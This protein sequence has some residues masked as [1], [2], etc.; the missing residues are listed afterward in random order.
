MSNI[1]DWKEYSR[2]ARNAAAEGCVLLRNEQHALP[3]RSG[4]TVSVFGRIQLDYYK[5]GA[6]SGGMVNVPYVHS[7]LDGLRSHQEIRIYEPVLA[8]YERWTKEHPFDHGNGWGTEPWCQEEMPLADAFVADAAAHSDLALIILGRTAGEDRDNTLQ[9]G[10]YYLT[11][12][13]RDMLHKVC[14]AFSR[15]AVVLNVGNIMDMNWVGEYQ[16]SSVLYVWQ[17]GMEGGYGA[18]DILCGLSPSGKLTDTVAFDYSDYPS[19]QNFGSAKANFYAEDLYVG[20]R[21]FETFAKDRVRYPFGFGLSYTTFAAQYTMTEAP[22]HLTVTATITNNGGTAGKEVIQIYAE[23]PQGLL[24]KPTR[25]LCAFAKTEALQPN[26]TATIDLTVQKSALA[27]YD[28]SGYTGHKSCYVLEAGTYT[29]YAGCDVRSAAPVGSFFIAE[30]FV[31]EALTECMAPVKAFSR[32]KPTVSTSTSA[33]ASASIDSGTFSSG[34][35][36]GHTSASSE[37]EPTYKI[38]RVPVPTRTI[39][40]MDK[41]TASLPTCLPYTGDTGIRLSDVKDGRADFAHFL[42]QLTDEDLRHIVHGEGMCSPKV[43]PGTAAAFGGITEHLQHFGI[44]AGCCSDGP[45]GIRMDCGATAFSLPSGTLL[46]STFNLPLVKELFTFEGLELHSNHIDALLG[47]GIN[48]HR[49]PL[50][51]RNFE[52]HSEDPYLTGMMA[53]AQAEGMYNA[54]VSGTLKHFCCN[55]QETSRHTV[56]SIVS[57]RA[58]REIYLKPFELCVRSGHIRSIMTSYNP[59]NGIWTAGNYDLNTSILR[60]EWG[61]TGMVMTDWWAKMNEE[62]EAPSSQNLAAMVRAQNDLF[63]VT[64][65]ATTYEDNLSDALAN[66]R[67]TRAELALSAENICRFLLE[68]PAFSILAGTDTPIEQKNRPSEFSSLDP[69]SMAAH[70]VSANTVI[71]LSG[72]P[73]NAGTFLVF[74][75]TFG[76]EGTYRFSLTASTEASEHAQMAVTLNLDGTVLHTY[77]YHGGSATPVTLSRDKEVRGTTHYLKVF[78]SHTGLKL[79][80]LRI[81]LVGVL[82]VIE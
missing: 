63:M 7:I 1:L 34:A 17:G 27:S 23:A 46:A 21:Y 67:L 9:E 41:R 33:S 72:Y 40:P 12:A 8:A 4:E 44:P 32:M 65:D 70:K 5:S 14:T 69:G 76:Q 79:H 58:L 64:T 78:F 25:A 29:L 24:G 18:A 6:G 56:D 55:N 28:D 62:G 52:Y 74:A 31:T 22:D 11:Q 71:P 60:K 20:Y 51:G 54:G 36:S 42:A 37:P 19:S 80:E 26:Q 61:Y 57:E 47:P 30:T 3:I 13:E 82:P 73:T 45:S 59:V 35:G 2:V 39:D 48:I 15:T 53:I 66:G 38:S 81:Q 16:P 10:S 77:S 49:N 43:T 68:S 50:N 75:L